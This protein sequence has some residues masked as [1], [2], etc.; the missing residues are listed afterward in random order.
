MQKEEVHL[1]KIRGRHIVIGT[2]HLLKP[3]EEMEVE[4]V[5][6]HL[7]ELF[8]EEPQMEGDRREIS[9]GKARHPPFSILWV[10]REI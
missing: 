3:V 10:L 1:V 2:C 5:Q 9:H 8:R 7:G 4:S 6:V